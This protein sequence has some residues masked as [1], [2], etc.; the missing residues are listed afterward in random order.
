VVVTAIP[1]EKQLDSVIAEIMARWGI[2]GLGAGIIQGNEILYARGFG[3]QSVETGVPVSFDSLFCLA[4]IAKCFVACAIMKLVEQGQLDLVAPL[5]RYLPYFR[6]NDDRYPQIT[7]RQML[8]HTSGMPDMDE[9]EYDD[10]VANPEYDERASERYVRALAN[11]KMVAAPGERFAYSNIAYNVLGDLIAKISGQTFERYM[12]EHILRPAGMPES[13]FYFPDLARERLA[14]PHLRAPGMTVSPYYPYHRAD[15]PASF[16][17]TSVRELCQWAITSLKRGHYDGQ[18]LLTPASYDLMWKPVAKRGSSPSLREEMGLGW[19]L[20]HF[21]GVRTVGHGG[22]GFG[23]TCFLALLPEKNRAAFI[24]CN[25]ESFGH[26]RALQAIL[27][28]TLD[29]EPQVGTVSWMVPI[30]DAL[31]I[32][33]IQAANTRYQAIKDDPG[34]FFDADE[35]ITLVY[36]LMSVKKFDLTIEVLEFNLSVFPNHADSYIFLAKN[37]LRKGNR[38]QAKSMLQKALELVPEEPM[39]TALLEKI[40]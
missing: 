8:S 1:M 5:V 39:A 33:G 38:A 3:V 34:Y 11:R 23:W 12:Q 18:R 21:E 17:Y 29:R 24:L 22:G 32:G 35:L 15:A 36:Q 28:V 13:T 6:L 4:S 30:C 40:R 16:L 27:N 9:D 37:Y 7:L 26:A 20:G 25:E 10:L 14:V 31:Q 2:P 19:T